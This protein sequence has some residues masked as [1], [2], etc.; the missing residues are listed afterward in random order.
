MSHKKKRAIVL[1]VGFAFMATILFVIFSKPSDDKFLAP[2]KDWVSEKKVEDY[3]VE[4]LR[5][6]EKDLEM[7]KNRLEEGDKISFYVTK[8]A[9][10][11]GII[12]NL[13][14]YGFIRDK[15]AFRY[16]LRHSGDT[17]TDG[18]DPIRVGKNGT[19][20]INAYYEISEDMNAW[21]I[22]DTLLNKP[23][24]FSS[25]GNYGNLFMP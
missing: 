3:F 4:K 19:I 5:F 12:S 21:E 9:T 6:T 18:V 11:D 7:Y 8:N 14:Y 1:L 10:L 2:G 20:D 16:A 22:A 15:Q 24:F 25:H 23:N 17:K 13:H